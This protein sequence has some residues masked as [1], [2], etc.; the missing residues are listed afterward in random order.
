[1]KTTFTLLAV[2]ISAAGCS[3][4]ARSVGYFKANLAEANTVNTGCV[5][6]AVRG[7]ECENAAT[8]LKVDKDERAS[9]ATGDYFA[10]GH[11]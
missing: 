11:K 8:A 3:P 2:L 9:K 7:A 4:P 5:S 10:S 6:G 1:M